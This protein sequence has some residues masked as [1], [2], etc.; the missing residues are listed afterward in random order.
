MVCSILLL[1][2]ICIPIV[3]IIVL[4]VIFIWLTWCLGILEHTLGALLASL[5]GGGCVGV[6]T[7]LE[8]WRRVLTTSNGQVT[9]APAV[10]A[11]LKYL[12][13]CNNPATYDTW[14]VLNLR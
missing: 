12:I 10:P 13:C 6:P 8:D 9:T 5:P 2:M 7:P 11:I 1:K 3:F 4:Y 14:L